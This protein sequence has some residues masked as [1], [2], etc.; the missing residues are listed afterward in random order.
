MRK[1]SN[2]NEL[3]IL[4]NVDENGQ[5]IDFPMGGGSSTKPSLKVHDNLK[6]AR[7]ARGFFKNTTIIKMTAYEIVD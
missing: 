2:T 1:K 4:A 6:S 5:I 7:R 3:F